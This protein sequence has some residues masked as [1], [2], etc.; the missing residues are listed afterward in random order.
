MSFL[1]S[2]NA[3]LK[4]TEGETN[5]LSQKSQNP[6]N[7]ELEAE[8]EDFGDIGII[9]I[10]ESPQPKLGECRQRLSDP[11]QAGAVSWAVLA[12]WKEQFPHMRPCPKVRDKS[13]YWM[14]IDRERCQGCPM[15]V[16][17]RTLH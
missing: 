11:G 9:G 3:C 5:S 16:Q 2:W 13:G 1:D 4:E 14:W 12:A 17:D 10:K 15:A 7:S 6:Q 8:K